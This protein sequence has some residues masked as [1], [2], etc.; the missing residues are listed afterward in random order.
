MLGDWGCGGVRGGSH[1]GGLE[2]R[3]SG[4]VRST[5][6]DMPSLVKAPDLS[7]NFSKVGSDRFGSPA[8]T[9]VGRLPTTVA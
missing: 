9:K 5:W 8:S 4:R 2:S 1:Q 7:R 3:G 6:N